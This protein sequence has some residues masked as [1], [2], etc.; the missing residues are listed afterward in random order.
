[1]FPQTQFTPPQVPKGQ[2]YSPLIT[3]SGLGNFFGGIGTGIK[4]FFTPKT[5]GITAPTNPL[6][7]LG[8]GYQ[9]LGL[10]GGLPVPP[11]SSFNV[12]V[13][14]TQPTTSPTH[15]VTT[16]TKTTPVTDSGT[17]TVDPNSYPS[18]ATPQPLTVA[19]VDNSGGTANPNYASQ[20]IP[21]VP[22]P[23]T[24][25]TTPLTTNGTIPSSAIGGNTT[26]QD[27]LSQR[28]QYEKS[29]QD[30]LL[31][32][33][34]TQVQGLQ[35]V[36]DA[37]YA[38]DTQSFAAG[39]GERATNDA[40]LANLAATSKA[41]AYGTLLGVNQTDL[42]NSLNV[43]PTT[44]GLQTSPNGDVYAQTRDPITGQTSIV[45]YG[46]IYN[47]T[48]SGQPSSTNNNGTQ[49]A[50]VGGTAYPSGTGMVSS[51]SI[52]VQL[53]GSV[54]TAPNGQAYV[55]QSKL[56]P[57][58]ETAQTIAA[59]NAGIPVLST[60]QSAAVKNIDYVKQQIGQNGIQGIIG[61][62]LSSGTTGRL[63]D[64]IVNPIKNYLQTDTNISTFNAYRETAINTI[65]SLAGG[66]GSGLRLTSG[67]IA[68]A[69]ANIPE[70]TDNLETANAKLQ[71]LNTF[72][73]NK[74][75]T[76]L[77]P[78]NSS[79]SNSTSGGSLYDF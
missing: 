67:E 56:T 72:L 47:G 45:P 48:F 29:Y 12:S 55:D 78:T 74:M 70:I 79:Q 59:K 14:Q 49:S 16:T 40:N 8:N 68:Q 19:Q 28:N 63:S 33:A 25:G 46:N 52:P 65:Q 62:I 11:A 35:N 58:L 39:M 38:G 9:P 31:A 60:D 13:P 27:V 50:S 53:Q 7:G 66:N 10:N 44:Q 15:T 24:F 34:Q 64:L 75:S 77:P 42:T 30:A 71:K 23:S 6:A 57:G 3:P 54:Y 26:Y 2:G 1:M 51:Q 4:N 41:N 69:S 32:A 17:P 73:D 61:S 18:Q 20:I 36:Q 43:A 21:P 76:V 22:S 37:R 5:G